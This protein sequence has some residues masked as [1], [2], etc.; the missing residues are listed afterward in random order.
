MHYAYIFI[1]RN[2][3]D[4]YRKAGP[5]LPGWKVWLWEWRFKKLPPNSEITGSSHTAIDR[6]MDDIGCKDPRAAG[7]NP[8]IIC[9]IAVTA[10]IDTTSV[11][12]RHW[13]DDCVRIALDTTCQG[14]APRLTITVPEDIL[15]VRKNRIQL[16]A[17]VFHNYAGWMKSKA[18]I[19]VSV[20][21]GLA[22]CAGILLAVFNCREQL[23]AQPDNASIISMYQ[24]LSEWGIENLKPSDINT[25]EIV[26]NR[27]FSFL[28]LK[29]MPKL[30]D[31]ERTSLPDAEFFEYLNKILPDE[32][33]QLTDADLSENAL[34]EAL[35]DL[36]YKIN[37]QMLEAGSNDILA[38]VQE[39]VSYKDWY[40][41]T[42]KTVFDGE[43]RINDIAY[44]YLVHFIPA[45]LTA[46]PDTRRKAE[47]VYEA[48]LQWD[49]NSLREEDCIRRPW[50]VANSFFQFLSLNRMG[51]SALSDFE[52]VKMLNEFIPNEPCLEFKDGEWSGMKL[53]AALETQLK[54]GG[55]FSSSTNFGGCMKAV[56]VLYS[57]KK[58][59]A[60]IH[61]T[62]NKEREQLY[63]K[64]HNASV[65]VENFI[66]HFNEGEK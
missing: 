6:R 48:L 16:I 8:V 58:R 20:I 1:E 47:L 10:R 3:G 53:W 34:R 14:I 26:A 43:G 24:I 40:I 11:S 66:K 45:N 18:V 27:F 19:A 23:P 5:V 42:R 61:N 4:G 25:P 55:S 56:V 59:W 63:K 60:K 44:S 57:D 65:S 15:I 21:V 9:R 2:F 32:H 49:V 41:N 38:Q 28:S 50:Y 54:A 51:L 37:H 22:I 30:S 52:C 36:L 39:K 17:E 64:D 62:F 31:V 46:T 13:I 35:S 33:Q 29:E 12:A 7:R